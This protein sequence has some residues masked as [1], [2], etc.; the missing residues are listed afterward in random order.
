MLIGEC[1]IR[2]LRFNPLLLAVLEAQADQ[3]HKFFPQHF[4]AILC[5]FEFTIFKLKDDVL[6][7]FDVDVLQV[8]DLFP[9]QG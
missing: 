2:D 5:D 1:I 4:K 6:N 9:V 7:C 8:V 3:M